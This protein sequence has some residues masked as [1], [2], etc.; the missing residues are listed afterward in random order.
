MAVPV[1]YM[2]IEG[3]TAVSGDPAAGET[4][5]FIADGVKLLEIAVDK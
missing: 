2:S 1:H 3:R 4:V 5:G